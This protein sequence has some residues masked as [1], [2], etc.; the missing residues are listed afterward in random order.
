MPWPDQKDFDRC[1]NSFLWFGSN[2]LVHKGLDRVLEA[3]AEM[4]EYHLTV[5]GPIH[6]ERDFLATYHRELFDTPNIRM[7]PLPT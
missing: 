1:R 4:P 3:F 6:E 7:A 5:C 2:A